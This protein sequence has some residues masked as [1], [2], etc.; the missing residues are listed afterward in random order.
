MVYGFSLVAFTVFGYFAWKNRSGKTPSNSVRSSKV[1]RKSVSLPMVIEAPYT[2]AFS[3]STYDI[4]IG[5][6]FIGFDDMDRSM[7]KTAVFG[8]RSGI[9][10]GD[11]IRISILVGRF[12][13][14]TCEGRVARIE[15]QSLGKYPDGLG[16]QFVNLSKR[17]V[18]LLNSLIE[19]APSEREAS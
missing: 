3:V 1:E 4:S 19:N 10:V 16:L 11:R 5:G 13:K 8:K 7:N 18:K 12:Q 14:I 9:K 2:Q 6:A 17:S 15:E